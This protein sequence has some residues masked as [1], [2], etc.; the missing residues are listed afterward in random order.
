VQEELLKGQLMILEQF[1]QALEGQPEAAGEAAAEP[2]VE[3]PGN[4][5][6]IIT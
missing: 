5:K 2:P 1:I 4:G 6:I 3:T